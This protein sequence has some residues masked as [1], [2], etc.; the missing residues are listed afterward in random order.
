MLEE[1][2]GGIAPRPPPPPP[3]AAGWDRHG[4]RVLILP[5][6]ENTSSS[7]SLDCKAA[8]TQVRT[9]ADYRNSITK[10]LFHRTLNNRLFKISLLSGKEWRT[11]VGAAEEGARAGGQGTDALLQ[12]PIISGSSS[13][14]NPIPTLETVVTSA[15]AHHGQVPPRPASEYPPAF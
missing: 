7:I 1:I 3:G 6:E 12:S 4:A 14:Q 10:D 5:D 15:S 2:F 11:A 8:R 9:R 13:Y